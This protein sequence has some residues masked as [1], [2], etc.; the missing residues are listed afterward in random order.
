MSSTET[1]VADEHQASLF[2]VWFYQLAVNSTCKTETV[3]WIQA[4]DL[5]QLLK[6]L[7]WVKWL[8]LGVQFLF[9]MCFMSST[10]T[11]NVTSQQEGAGFKPRFICSPFLCAPFL[12]VKDM[13]F[14][15]S[16]NCLAC[17]CEC[18]CLSTCY[19]YQTILQ[20]ASMRIFYIFLMSIMS[21][22]LKSF[23]HIWEWQL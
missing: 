18:F 7:V 15:W 11:H 21:N 8:L 22:F 3:H 12:W 23:Y 5:Q 19:H 17:W 20:N 4:I 13:H 2:D 14:R 10:F 16:R 9:W 1:D 6:P